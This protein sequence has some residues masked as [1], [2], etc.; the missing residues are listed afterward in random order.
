MYVD[1][2]IVE[3]GGNAAYANEDDEDDYY[4]TISSCTLY[5]FTGYDPI[6]MI[7]SMTTTANWYP[8]YNYTQQV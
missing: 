1:I 7:R 5:Q 8:H 6:S 3:S 4:C 2:T